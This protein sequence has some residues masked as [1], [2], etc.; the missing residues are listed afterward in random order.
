MT[1]TIKVKIIT[2]PDPK[3]SERMNLI[4]VKFQQK[5]ALRLRKEKMEAA[6][7]L[8]VALLQD[9]KNAAARGDV[10]CIIHQNLINM[11]D[12]EYLMKRLR[13]DYGFCCNYLG[14]TVVVV[15][16]K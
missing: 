5:E 10:N 8:I 9:I 13:D 4:A 12:S 3:L 16:G 7:R 15:W 1:K 14:C 2:P 6:E 11:V